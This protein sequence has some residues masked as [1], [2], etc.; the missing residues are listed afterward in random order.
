MKRFAL[1]STIISFVTLY[2]SYS[3][4][5]NPLSEGVSRFG[6]YSGSLLTKKS[7]ISQI[8]PKNS[9]L[10]D[11]SQS[12][13]RDLYIG[14]DESTG[15]ADAVTFACP[16]TI[17]G[18]FNFRNDKDY[19]KIQTSY[20]C[21]LLTLSKGTDCSILIYQKYTSNNVNYYKK[22][23]GFG[24]SSLGG[25]I[26]LYKNVDYYFCVS[27]PNSSFIDAYSFNVST[28]SASLDN[29]FLKISYTNDG[30]FSNYNVI[31]RDYSNSNE[32]NEFCGNKESSVNLNLSSSNSCYGHTA[33]G[34]QCYSYFQEGYRG[35][36]K[37]NW[38]PGNSTDDED[39]L[40][41]YS[42]NNLLDALYYPGISLFLLK[43]QTLLSN[44]SLE[45]SRGTAFKVGN[46]LMS[47][48]HMMVRY[49]STIN[50]LDFSTYL[51]AFPGADSK[52]HTESLF[53]SYHISKCYLPCEY[54]V[55]ILDNDC[56]TKYDWCILELGTAIVMPQI[57]TLNNYLGLK[58]DNYSNNQT[59]NSRA[60]GYPVLVG[61]EP[62]IAR[63]QNDPLEDYDVRIT[64]SC[65]Q[66]KYLTSYQ[67]FS[68]NIDLTSGNSGGPICEIDSQNNI[69]VVGI[70]SGWSESYN[71]ITPINKIN[72]SLLE[73][74]NDS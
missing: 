43:F 56:K 19:W 5:V 6:V 8:R 15:F 32:Y 13:S 2:L 23:T 63:T 25:D 70:C 72:Y 38:L 46:Y 52:Q 44:N 69:R 42:Y 37:D 61:W 47:S 74:L 14:D 9:F 48:A 34:G 49:S 55:N 3:L 11:Y 22:V 27:Q 35:L 60:Y 40:F 33:Q 31:L 21:R 68:S 24:T 1:L 36:F 39:R 50:L 10:F 58:Y 53:G 64:T 57:T 26:F 45:E 65:G 17:V 73:E 54:I 4:W 12:G 51:T 20:S 59:F 62:F 71:R 28:S 41:G 29:A 30:A 66:I 67:Y 18:F 7:I 16:S